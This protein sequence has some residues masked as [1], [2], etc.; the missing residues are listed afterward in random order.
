MAAATLGLSLLAGCGDDSDSRAESP[1]PSSPAEATTSP[2]PEASAE[3]SPGAGPKQPARTG[4]AR[5]GAGKKQAPGIARR[6][7]PVTPPDTVSVP[8]FFVGDAPGGPRLFREMRAVDAADPLTAAAA[9]TTS[10]EALDPDYRSLFSAG[11]VSSVG[12]DGFGRRGVYTVRL[13]DRR[14][15]ERPAG[16]SRRSANLA[17]QQLVR[18]L[19]GAGRSRSRVVFSVGSEQVPL[20][21][22]RRARGFRAAPPLDV[23]ALA[24]ITSPSQGMTVRGSFTARGLASSFEATVPWELRRRDKVV[25]SGFATASGWMDKLYPWQAEVDVSGLAPGR[26][27]FVAFTDDPTGEGPSRE[28]VGP[29]RDTKTVVVRPR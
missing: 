14:W 4:S 12:F 18:T 13:A 29:T 28:G 16:M 27:T 21:G 7:G 1:P 17:V 24:N 8:V 22:V 10:G 6:R 23:L 25:R 20:F 11:S 3:A 19:H 15:T 9:L 2:A 26:Y 5:P